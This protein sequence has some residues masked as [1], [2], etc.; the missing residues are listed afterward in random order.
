MKSLMGFKLSVVCFMILS[1]PASQTAIEI[2]MSNALESL[3]TEEE[4]KMACLSE[5]DLAIAVREFSSRRSYEELERAQ[6]LLKRNAGRSAKCRKQ[7]ID[8]LMFAMDRPQIDLFQ[9]FDLW[10]YGSV[11]LGDL[12]ATEALDLLIDHLDLNDGTSIS[13]SHYPA[14]QGVIKM[15][16]VAIPKLGVALRRNPDRNVRLDAVFCIA[17]IG[18]DTA[19]PVLKQALSSESDLCVSKFIRVS[20]DALDNKQMPGQITSNDR[21]KW[22]AAFSCNE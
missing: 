16:T 1:Q 17:Q 3:A 6:E 7:V 19:M 21:A 4:A 22:Y 15:G 20:I 11:L 2:R 18:G 9:D 5:H 12:K 14:M 13:V 8:A 10:R